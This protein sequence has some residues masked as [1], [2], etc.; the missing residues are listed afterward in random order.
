MLLFELLEQGVHAGDDLLID[1]VF[2]GAHRALQQDLGGN[3]VETWRGEA[4]EVG[5]GEH[6]GWGIGLRPYESMCASDDLCGDGDGI[7][8]MFHRARMAA[9]AFYA[10]GEIAD[11]GQGFTGLITECAHGQEGMDMETEDRLAV[12]EL[13]TFGDELAAGFSFYRAAG[14]AFFG[15]AGAG[16]V[17]AAVIRSLSSGPCRAAA[18]APWGLFNIDLSGN[19][20]LSRIVASPE[21]LPARV[22][23]RGI[24]Y[25][26]S[27]VNGRTK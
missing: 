19:E 27:S 11:I 24:I 2:V 13:S 18:R 16:A 9:F 6:G 14:I 3:D 4:F 17:L 23:D 21:R 8:D 5:D 22:S 15:A 1:V 10:D 7:D 25:Q 12:V 26:T 20:R